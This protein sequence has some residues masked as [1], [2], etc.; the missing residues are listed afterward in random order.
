MFDEDKAMQVSL[1]R[2]LELHADEEIL[3]PKLE[4]PQIDVEHPHAE[5]QRVDTSTQ[6]ES[7]RVG[8]KHT[9]EADILLD[10]AQENVGAP[11]SQHRKRR[12][13]ER[14]IGC[15]ALMGA[16]VVIFINLPFRKQCNNHF[17]LMR[18]WRSM[19]A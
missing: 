4:R 17:G 8:R 3:A 19:T 7:S 2:E 13:R 11:S 12:L 16:H 14:Y 5:V 1:E 15:M 9:R 18:W 10:D 6:E